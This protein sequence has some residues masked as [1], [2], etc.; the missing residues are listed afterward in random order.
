MYEKIFDYLKPNGK[1][2][3]SILSFKLSFNFDNNI[4]IE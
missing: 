4:E 3:I 1:D 2:E